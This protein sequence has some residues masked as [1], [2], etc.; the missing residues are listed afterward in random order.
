MLR[1]FYIALSAG[2]LL[3]A[4]VKEMTIGIWPEYEHAGSLVYFQI[5]SDSTSLP[6]TLDITVPDSVRL[7]MSAYRDTSGIGFNNIEIMR[8]SSSYIPV[9]IDEPRKYVQFYHR[10]NDREGLLNILS[11]DFS[12]SQDIDSLFLMVQRPLFA[13]SF[14]MNLEDLDETVDEFD[15]VYKFKSFGRVASSETIPISIRYDNPNSTTTKDMLRPHD[16][17]HEEQE[18]T[19]KNNF[20]VANM[21]KKL[22]MKILTLLIPMII[23]LAII[24][25]QNQSNV[26]RDS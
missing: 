9:Y 21:Y 18:P 1:A 22:P 12:A 8:S 7:A 16:F 17:S 6:Y 24:I 26:S 13:T 20:M 5:E 3:S 19:S 2:I 23:I 25:R 10:F 11:Y 14:E 4:K 15:I